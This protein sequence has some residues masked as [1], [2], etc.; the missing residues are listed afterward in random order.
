MVKISLW[1]TLGG[2][3]FAFGPLLLAQILG[4]LSGDPDSAFNEG[5]GFGGLIWLMFYTV[6]LGAIVVLVGLV[7]LVVS[8]IRGRGESGS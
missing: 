1:L 4:A 7:L 2:A 3:L 5:E 6:P 8:L